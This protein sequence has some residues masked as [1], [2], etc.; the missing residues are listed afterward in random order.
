MTDGESEPVAL[1]ITS[2]IPN[3]ERAKAELNQIQKTHRWDPNLPQEVLQT[4]DQA[5]ELGDKQ[6][7][8][9]AE[10][11]FCS[12]S[13]YEEVRAAV[14]NTDNDEV[15]NTV[16][17]WILGMIFVTIGSGLNMFLSMR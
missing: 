8:E 1:A 13:P 5:L 4:I 16:R 6:A 9:K 2:V 17:A 3:L 7:I 11:L 15:A 10:E 14:R 12:N